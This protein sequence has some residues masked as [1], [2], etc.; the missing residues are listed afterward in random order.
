[1]EIKE[2]PNKPQT[3]Q[4]KQPKLTLDLEVVGQNH[5]ILQVR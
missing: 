3:K 4:K 1:M 2:K 5:E